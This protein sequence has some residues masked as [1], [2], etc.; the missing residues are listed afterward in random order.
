MRDLKRIRIFTH[1]NGAVFESNFRAG[2]RPVSLPDSY[3]NAGQ[4]PGQPLATPGSEIE[5]RLRAN[6]LAQ[7]GGFLE[8]AP[9]PFA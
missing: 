2:L 3:A 5:N 6:A 9:I 8:S 4:V 1:R 7:H